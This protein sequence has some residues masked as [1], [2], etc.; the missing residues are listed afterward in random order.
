MLGEGWEL[1]AQ[2]WE[3]ASLKGRFSYFINYE[4][5]L[6]IVFKKCEK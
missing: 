3:G 2:E 6:L 4:I 5:E 1:G